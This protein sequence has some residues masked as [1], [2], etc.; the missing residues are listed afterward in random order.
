MSD[1]RE[2]ILAAALKLPVDDRILIANSLYESADPV[3]PVLEQEWAQEVA[4]RLRDIDEGK[5]EMLDGET[6]MRELR[7]WVDDGCPK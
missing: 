1:D 5:V 4:G 7:Q 2:T 6:V 3:D